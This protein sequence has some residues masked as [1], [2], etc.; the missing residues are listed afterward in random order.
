MKK[1]QYSEQW[2]WIL[3]SALC[4]I[5]AG[6]GPWF[7]NPSTS[8]ENL[9]THHGTVAWFDCDDEAISIGSSG[10]GYLEFIDSVGNKRNE[11][12]STLWISIDN[13]QG[14]LR[15]YR[16]YAGLTIYYYKYKIQVLRL[17]WEPLKPFTEINIQYLIESESADRYRY[18]ST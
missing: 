1:S 13:H 6:C 9:K 10:Y 15:I 2:K 5:L 4:L 18:C 17:G 7:S 11:N 8:T 14:P 3:I 12:T 16:A